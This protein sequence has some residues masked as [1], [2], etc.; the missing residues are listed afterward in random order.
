MYLI[1]L[2]RRINSSNKEERTVKSNR[3]KHNK[4]NI[5]ARK[6]EAAVLDNLQESGHGRNEYIIIGRVQQ[7][8]NSSESERNRVS[9]TKHRHK[10]I[11]TY[12]PVRNERHHHW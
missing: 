5:T 2:E 9:D 7:H 11:K 12:P 1:H 6:T 10:S 3:T 8:I 4:E